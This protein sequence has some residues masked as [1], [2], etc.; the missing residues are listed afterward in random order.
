M[1]FNINT[2][3][4]YG[5]DVFISPHVEFRRPHLV[6]I[7]NHI[8]IDTGFYI[9]TG[10]HLLNHIHIAPYVT[11]VG[12][13]MGM[14]KMGNF[15]NL[16]AGCKVICGSDSFLGDGLISAPGIPDEY[17]DV[18]KTEPVVLQNFANV[19]ANVVILPGVILAEGSVAGACSLVTKNTEPWTIYTGIPAKPVKSRNSEKMK[20]Y[21]KRMG[22]DI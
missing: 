1:N 5:K 21:A 22:Y 7:G 8:A 12:G 18:L 11:V 9:S 15:T 14:L 20:E 6:N 17:R 13:A 3:A 16:S 4:S 2:L 19:G 10:A